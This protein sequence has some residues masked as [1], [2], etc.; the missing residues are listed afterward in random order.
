MANI[1]NCNKLFLCVKAFVLSCLL[2]PLAVQAQ[3][4]SF[5]APQISSGVYQAFQ[6]DLVKHPLMAVSLPEQSYAV[7]RLLEYQR[8]DAQRSYW[9][10]LRLDEQQQVFKMR[11]RFEVWQAGLLRW[12]V[13]VAPQ[14]ALRYLSDEVKSTGQPILPSYLS[15]EAGLLY[16]PSL[17]GPQE[18]KLR[19]ELALEAADLILAD[20]EK[21]L[22]Q[23]TT[24]TSGDES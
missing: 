11:V 7:L 16:F 2:W 18:A 9:A 3:T 20:L 4:R 12:Q 17:S 22:N 14:R 6:K 1:A 8:E 23:S 24:Q 21:Y 13:T 15:Q 10:Q 5:A 19:Q